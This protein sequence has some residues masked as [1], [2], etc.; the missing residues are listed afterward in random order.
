MKL[1]VSSP[2]RKFSPPF[3]NRLLFTYLSPPPWETAFSRRIFSRSPSPGRTPLGHAPPLRL[4]I[5]SNSDRVACKLAARCGPK[6]PAEFLGSP[7]IRATFSAAPENVM[8][9]QGHSSSP[10]AG[11]TLLSHGGL[12]ALPGGMPIARTSSRCDAYVVPRVSSCLLLLLFSSCAILPPPGEA[13]SG[14][15]GVQPDQE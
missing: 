1:R 6:A 13:D 14:S 15:A 11:T 8:R 10:G 3:L 5:L 2:P 4:L 7:S 9:P 12:A